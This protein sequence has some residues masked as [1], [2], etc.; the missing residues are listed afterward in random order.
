M[1]QLLSVPEAGDTRAA[2]ELLPLVYGEL[3]RLAADL[4]FPLDA[5]PGDLDAAQWAEVFSF[6]DRGSPGN[7]R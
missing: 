2:G 1:T 3:R 6:L 5:R 7:R 4:G